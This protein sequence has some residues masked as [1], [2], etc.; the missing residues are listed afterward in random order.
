LAT[1]TVWGV[2]SGVKLTEAQVVAPVS[3]EMHCDNCHSDG[4]QEGIATGVVEKNILRLHDMENQDEYPPG[5]RGAL[6]DRAP[7]LCAECHASNALGAPGVRGIPSLSKAIHDEHEEEVSQDLRGCYQCHP[8]P[9]TRCLRDVMAQ[10]GMDC[11]D[12]HGTM[13]EVARN[14]NPWLNEP[15]CDSPGCHDSGAHDQDQPLYRMSREHGGLYCAA[16]HDSPHA[17]AP[18]REHNDQIKFLALQGHVG[19]LDTCTVCHASVPQAP[20]KGPH[21]L[22]AAIRDQYLYLPL[23]QR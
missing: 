4:Q 20:G 13:R 3:T 5:H 12:C 21:G 17:I 8:G 19:T 15:R 2:Q 1:V 7:I 14:P 23:A 11:V 9:Q 22:S 6:V 18:S 10:R 16:C